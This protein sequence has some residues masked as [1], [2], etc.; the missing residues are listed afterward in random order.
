MNTTLGV[1][2]FW[3][4]SV[5]KLQSNA[6]ACRCAL[7]VLTRD[8][9]SPLTTGKRRVAINCSHVEIRRNA[10]YNSQY[11]LCTSKVYAR[12]SSWFLDSRHRLISRGSALTR[13]VVS[14]SLYD[15]N[16]A[17]LGALHRT[18]RIDMTMA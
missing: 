7:F 3:G 16:C 11:D 2:T 8:V 14:I 4:H 10:D 17:G 5:H 15:T 1:L 9:T 13:A 12:V 6:A 18:T